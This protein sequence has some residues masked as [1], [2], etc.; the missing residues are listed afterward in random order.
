MSQPSI[1]KVNSVVKREE[2]RYAGCQ[3]LDSESNEAMDWGT[4]CQLS[5]GFLKSS[6]GWLWHRRIAHI[7]MSQLKKVFKRGLVLGLKDVEFE[8]DKLCGACQVGKQVASHHPM[9]A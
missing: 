9:K 1:S 4:C 6:I 2:Q 5:K 3:L 7:G 8:K